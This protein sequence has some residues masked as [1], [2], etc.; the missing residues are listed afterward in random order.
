[1]EPYAPQYVAEMPE[2]WMPQSDPAPAT[3]AVDP[4]VAAQRRLIRLLALALALAALAIV[5]P[6][7]TGTWSRLGVRHGPK[8]LLNPA[9][10]QAVMQGSYSYSTGTVQRVV[11]IETSQKRTF[12]CDVKYDGPRDQAYKVFVS[13]DGQHWISTPYYGN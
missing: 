12:I 7:A 1:M 5:L 13:A 6:Y 3:V 4:K 11:C 8:G 9:S 2:F 10:L